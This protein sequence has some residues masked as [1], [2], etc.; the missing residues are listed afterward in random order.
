MA[1]NIDKIEEQLWNLQ[2][3]CNVYKSTDCLADWVLFAVSRYINT[4]RAT[5]QFELRF[6]A[7]SNDDLM[8]AIKYCLNYDK[9][10]DSIIKSFNKF[11]YQIER[12]NRYED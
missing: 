9:S 12:R 7:M 10:D 1:V 3:Q 4:G 2:R 5:R 6:V 8:E 11:M